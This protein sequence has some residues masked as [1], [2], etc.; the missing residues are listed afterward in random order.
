MHSNV[1]AAILK[2]GLLAIRW[3]EYSFVQPRGHVTLAGS[4]KMAG[5]EVAWHLAQGTCKYTNVS[6][7]TFLMISNFIIY[8]SAVA[9]CTTVTYVKV[10]VPTPKLLFPTINDYFVWEIYKYWSLMMLGWEWMYLTDCPFRGPGSFHGC[11]G[12]SLADH[13]LPTHP[14]PAYQRMAQSPLNGTAWVGWLMFNHG[15]TIA[16]KKGFSRPTCTYLIVV[17]IGIEDAIVLGFIFHHFYIGDVQRAFF[18]LSE[19]RI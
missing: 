1:E 8:L 5:R 4:I 10:A 6:V 19:L 17:H 18:I 3:P 7:W 14:E 15:E 11:G 9:P 2:H 16:T 12:F 13:A